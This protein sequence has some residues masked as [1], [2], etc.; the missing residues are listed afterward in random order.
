MRA[1]FL[2]AIFVLIKTSIALFT[3]GRIKISLRDTLCAILN[4]TFTITHQVIPAWGAAI[5]T[6][7][8]V[9]ITEFPIDTVSCTGNTNVVPC[10]VAIITG[11]T[12][13][14]VTGIGEHPLSALITMLYHTSLVTVESKVSRLT[15]V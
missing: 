1:T 3:S 4:H 7:P 2:T 14:L 9:A 12:V 15:A 11:L 10:I 13:H 8:R 5:N 6:F